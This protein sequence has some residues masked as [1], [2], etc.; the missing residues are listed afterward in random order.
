M[1]VAIL[2]FNARAGDAIGNQVAEKLSYLLDRGAD[3]RIFVEHDQ[4]L[5]PVVRPFVC[6]LP[7]AEPAGQAWEYI[8]SSDLVI[9]EFGQ[10]YSLLGLLPLLA[11]GKPRILLD[12]HGVTPPEFWGSHNREALDRG[13]KSLG[14]VWCADAALVHSKYMADELHA[15][16]RFPEQRCHL[17]GYPLDTSLFYHLGPTRRLCKEP[18]LAD[19]RIL[20]FVGRLAPNKRVTLLVEALARL[21][22]PE[23]PIHAVIVGATCDVYASEAER[24]RQLARELDVEDRLHLLGHISEDRLADAYRSA[25]VFVM[26]SRHEGFCIPLIEAMACGVP[27]VAARAAALPETVAGA[28]LTF[29]PDDVDDLVRQ[30]RHVVEP[31]PTLSGRAPASTVVPPMC[32]FRVAVVSFR[33]GAQFAGGAEA[34]LRTIASALCQAG[35]A[36]E[37]FTTCNQSEN[38][39]GNH[40]SEGTGWIDDILVHRFPID[41]HDRAQHLESVRLLLQGDGEVSPE[42]ERLYLRHSIHSSG[43]IAGLVKRLPEFDVVVVGPYLFGLTHDV[44]QVSPEKT[45]LVPCFHDEPSARLECWRKAYQRVGGILYHSLEEKEL[46]E[47]VLGLNHP[48]GVCLGALIDGSVEGRAEDGRKRV[49]LDRPYLIYC[50]RYSAQKNVPLL[51]DYAR[52]YSQLHPDRFQFA[53]MGEGEVPILG[54]GWARDLGFVPERAKHDVL[55]GAA[56]LVQLSCQESL[57]RV[58]LEAWAQGT[59]VLVHRASR[60]LAGHLDRCQ[61]GQTLDDFGSFVKALDDLSQHPR[62]WQ[63]MGQRGRS[64]VQSR[65]GQPQKFV[66]VLE[67]AMGNLS[68]PLAEQMRRQGLLR[69]ADFERARWRER[70]GRVVEDLLESPPLPFHERLEVQPRT[71]IRTVALGQSSALVPV[72]VANRGSHTVVHEGPARMVL[73]CTIRDEDGQDCRLPVFD[74]PLPRLLMPGQETALAMRIPVPSGAGSYQVRLY[75]CRTDSAADGGGVHEADSCLLLK[76]EGQPTGHLEQ[77]CT[78]LLE[79]VQR[80]L[81]ELE[82]R[83]LLPDKYADITQGFMA[84]LKLRIKRKLLGN[85]KHAYV[86]VLSR[87]QSRFNQRVLA[88]LQE[89]TECCSILDHVLSGAE[90]TRKVSLGSGLSATPLTASLESLPTSG[91]GD[92][93]ARLLRDLLAEVT[94]SHERITA[95]EER[96]TRL[97]ASSLQR[98]LAGTSTR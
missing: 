25:D 10:F 55:A 39:W 20:L 46:A 18:A 1:R 26:P 84:S 69:A 3:V 19:A 27:V 43:L 77:C 93:L 75:A 15:A 11:G 24:C 21:Q 35:H 97:E 30:L 34:S 60:P 29:A 42:V 22:T 61:G 12:Y 37:I 59:P 72:R 44:V 67:A 68:I 38:D 78:P 76:V 36:V 85:F 70:F 73:R 6:L 33:Y 63:E 81:G 45:L 91:Q 14:L 49:G 50:G 40:L 28:G 52:R 4:Q 71:P 23:P 79:T 92:E 94:R 95:L 9:V 48:A 16:T 87:Q 47:R 13:V 88:A 7:S 86:D 90:K 51:L 57:S 54:K 5:H 82:D 31:S 58:V 98:A 80:S 56:A 89:L 32:R 17:M 62:T 83:W 96:L 2:T 53:F 64:Y 74:T 66:Q 8:S 65:Y 41:A